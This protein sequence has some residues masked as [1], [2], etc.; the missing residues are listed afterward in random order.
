MRKLLNTLFI[1][2]SNIYLSLEGDDI[3]LLKEKEKFGR[4]PLHNIESIITFGYT[5]ASPALIGYCANK[6]ISIA[7]MRVN[8]RFLARVV[9][10]S[11]GNVV[12]R[13]EQYRV[14]D[15]EEQSALIA[16]NFILGKIYNNKWIIERMTRDHPLRIDINQFKETS[17][18]L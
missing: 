8:G 18:Q 16:R 13:K 10:K 9:G 14:S 1:T 12:L 3:V 17:K 15:C 6:N 5:G 11:R 4:V 2:Q 7:V